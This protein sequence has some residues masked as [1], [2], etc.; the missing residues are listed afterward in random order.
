MLSPTESDNPNSALPSNAGS[1]NAW[2]TTCEL[3][4]LP[5]E[6]VDSSGGSTCELYPN[7]PETVTSPAPLPTGDAI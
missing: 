3:N 2:A 7:P 1:A 6:S 5:A 4:G